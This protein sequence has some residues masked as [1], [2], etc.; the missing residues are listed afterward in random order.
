MPNFYGK[1]FREDAKKFPSA[2]LLHARR[3][4]FGLLP[5]HR[6]NARENAA[7]SEK[8]TRYAVSFTDTFFPCR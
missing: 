5:V 2:L 6:L 8:P 7:G 1:K 4:A 3:I